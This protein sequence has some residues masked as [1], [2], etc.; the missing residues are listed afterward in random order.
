M[1]ETFFIITGFLFSVT[2]LLIVICL[3]LGQ[4]QDYL[5]NSWYRYY[6]NLFSD[7]LI[8]AKKWHDDGSQDYTVAVIEGYADAV[9][10]GLK[11]DHSRIRD[12]ARKTIL[13]KD[14]NAKD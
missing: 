12:E 3:C 14:T 6:K 4:I 9:I 11:P 8:E 7:Y 2:V 5:N 13:N 10:R 1:A